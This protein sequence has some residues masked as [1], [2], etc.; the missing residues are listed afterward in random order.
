MC[1]PVSR[2]RLS[3]AFFQA[4]Y[5]RNWLTFPQYTFQFQHIYWNWNRWHSGGTADNI[6]QVLTV[7]GLWCDILDRYSLITPLVCR[8]FDRIPNTLLIPSGQTHK[9]TDI[10]H[11]GVFP[12]LPRV[13]CIGVYNCVPLEFIK[14]PL[15]EETSAFVYQLPEPTLNLAYFDTVLRPSNIG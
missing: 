11:L 1:Y 13:F 14:G 10:M 4:N 6:D 7:S 8:C 5:S 12:N 2:L 3:K 9:L 15:R